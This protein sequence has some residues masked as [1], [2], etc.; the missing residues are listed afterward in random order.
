MS[1]V[2]DSLKGKMDEHAEDGLS[3][4]QIASLPPLE[5]KIVR[6]L[7]RE[8]EVSHGA[9][10]EA[11]QALPEAERPSRNDMEAALEN[12]ATEG[13]VIRRGE[14]DSR[15]Y[16]PNMRRKAPSTL[17]KAIWSS[18]GSRIAETKSARQTGD[19]GQ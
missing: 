19:E 17:A 16:E 3:P 9:V 4:I 15:N 12:L 18:L 11:M 5:R 8:L 14:G 6:L 2:F 1:G 10:W 13:W 7:L